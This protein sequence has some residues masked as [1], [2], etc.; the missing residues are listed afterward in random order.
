M[1]VTIKACLDIQAGTGEV[2][3]NLK[4]LWA[5]WENILEATVLENLK[6]LLKK[7]IRKIFKKTRHPFHVLEWITVNSPTPTPKVYK[8]LYKVYKDLKAY[9][10]K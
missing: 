7:L 5:R 6:K 3:K 2:V 4:L 8:D 1:P 9:K 10:A